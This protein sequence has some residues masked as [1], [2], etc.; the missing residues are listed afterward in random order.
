MLKESPP[1]LLLWTKL[2]SFLPES[3]IENYL[4]LLPPE[5]CQGI[6]CYSQSSDRLTRIAAR[7][8]VQQGLKRLSLPQS[9]LCTWSLDP[10]SRPHLKGDLDFNISHS[11]NYA[12]VAITRV[13]RVGVD[14]EVTQSP[15]P[16]EVLDLFS[17]EV[18]QQVKSASCPI[19]AFYQLWTNSEAALK[20]HGKG[21]LIA[22]ETL[23][24]DFTI[25]E[26][27]YSIQTRQFGQHYYS[28]AHSYPAFSLEVV[29]MPFCEL[30]PG[31]Q[32]NQPS[33]H[34]RVE[35][36]NPEAI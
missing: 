1:V 20:A 28:V 12:L 16:W 4:Q 18:A 31:L 19:S 13:G 35:S 24:L 30:Y 23:R 25:E 26:S 5:S 21:L 29:Y 17:P 3:F 9:L 22:P 33:P 32:F 8:L 10:F 34:L 2:P 15:P 6:S 36:Q 14:I 11:G 7:S 27:C